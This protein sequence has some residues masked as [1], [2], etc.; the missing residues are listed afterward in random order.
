M[1]SAVYLQSPCGRRFERHTNRQVAALAS[2][3]AT[4]L[5][6]ANF[7]TPGQELFSEYRS[8]NSGA[9]S[10]SLQLRAMFASPRRKIPRFVAV[11]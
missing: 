5:P 11:S 9:I 1:P 7:F 8:G 6:L 4:Q 2:A 3:K 10:A